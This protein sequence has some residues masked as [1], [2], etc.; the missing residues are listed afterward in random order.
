MKTA[1]LLFTVMLGMTMSKSLFW[2]CVDDENVETYI[3]VLPSPG[4][5]VLPTPNPSHKN[6]LQKIEWQ[7]KQ[8][9]R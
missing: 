2:G 4:S 5:L 9:G 6:Q 3:F 7:M 1:G 8:K